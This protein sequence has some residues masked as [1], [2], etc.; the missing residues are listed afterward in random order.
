MFLDKTGFFGDNVEQLKDQSQLANR[1]HYQVLQ[2]L[3]SLAQFL[4]ESTL[5]KENT[6][7]KLEVEQIIV[8]SLF[9]KMINRAE[10][11]V[12]LTQRGLEADAKLLLRAY[13]EQ[14]IML[15]LISDDKNNLEIYFAKNIIKHKKMFN[16][17]VANKIIDPKNHRDT[18]LDVQAKHA[19]LLQQLNCKN[20]I[21][22]DQLARKANLFE[23]YSKMYRI[24]SD[25]SHSS[26]N[27]LEGYLS[28]NGQ[29]IIGI[30][31]RHQD[32][33]PKILGSICH[34]IH[35]TIDYYGKFSGIAEMDCPPEIEILVSESLSG[36][37]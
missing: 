1:K 3:S 2:A 30:I 35:L 19:N 10:S 21:P 23:L 13:I 17:W 28:G 5:K 9:I 32:E 27:S 22:I 11:I 36:T 24:F 33:T 6:P 31:N 7:T 16:D 14:L 34:M 18:I 4:I 20:D 29:T 26:I 25:E 12:C 37:N 15:K 8:L